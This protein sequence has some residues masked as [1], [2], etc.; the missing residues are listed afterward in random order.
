MHREKGTTLIELLAALALSGIVLAVSFSAFASVQHLWSSY[1]Q[2][3]IDDEKVA[4]AVNTAAK[5]LTDT[6][7]ICFFADGQ[8]G[9]ELR[10]KTG[11][12]TQRYNFKA[13][14]LHNRELTLYDLSGVDE[15]NFTSPLPTAS[16]TRPLALADNVTQMEVMYYNAPLASGTS[17]NSGETFTLRLTFNVTVI[18]AFGRRT[19]QTRTVEKTIKLF[20]E[21]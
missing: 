1:A 8:S 12:G 9:P 5:Y 15:T 19:P 7:E 2:K 11:M 13:I 6:L 4:F 18:D 20:K 3:H 16:Y 17:L 14:T 10:F 21:R